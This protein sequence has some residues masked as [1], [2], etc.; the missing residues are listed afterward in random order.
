VVPQALP[1]LELAIPL[2]D[3]AI[4]LRASAVDVALELQIPSLDVN[5]PVQGVGLTSE[6]VMDSPKGPIGDAVWSTAFWYRGG[7][8]PGDVGTATFAGHVNDPLGVPEIFANIEDL[9]IGDLIIIRDTRTDTD[10]QFAVDAVKVYSLL[11]TS[12]PAVLTQIFGAGP[13]AG[14]GPQPTLDGLSRI[15]LI[16]CAGEIVDGAFDHY[17]VVYATRISAIEK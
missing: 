7:G 13:V 1:T 3:P 6:N 12:Q 14:L 4:D 16:T 2:F 15:T 11:E 9:R 8:V 10:I 17:T 5:A